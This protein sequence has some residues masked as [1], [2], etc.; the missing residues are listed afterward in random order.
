VVGEVVGQRKDRRQARADQVPVLGE[1][2]PAQRESWIGF[3]AH[4][5]VGGGI[6]VEMDAPPTTVGI[7]GAQA[8]GPTSATV[9]GGIN[10]G[11]GGG[12]AGRNAVVRSGHAAFSA[13]G[14]AGTA[15]E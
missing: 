4:R 14:I 11:P 8:D 15:T 7:S 13:E 12:C 5:A 10:R 9:A 3:S 1:I 6:E 2:S